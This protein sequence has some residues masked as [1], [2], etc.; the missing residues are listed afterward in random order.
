MSEVNKDDVERMIKESEKFKEEDD[1]IKLKVESKNRLENYC[2][3]LRNTMLNDE[4][5]KT[6]L[7]ED[8]DIVDKVTQETLDWLDEDE[9]SRT[10][11]DYTNKQSDVEK[12]LSPLVQ[13]A[14]QSNTNSNS[15]SV[16]EPVP[17]N[18]KSEEQ[19]MD[20]D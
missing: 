3:S 8:Y 12:Q 20:V 17:T 18:M 15:D 10:A 1:K 5:M 9:S 4:K 14:Y 6:A 2:Y 11:D 7:G 16:N 19:N 13:K